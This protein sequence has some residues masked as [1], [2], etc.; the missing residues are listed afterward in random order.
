MK[1]HNFGR[2]DP[3]RHGAALSHG[4]RLE[5]QFWA[6][7]QDSKAKLREAAAEVREK[8]SA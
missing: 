3:N 2:F 1:L 5:S 6:E 4:G 7:F 8:I